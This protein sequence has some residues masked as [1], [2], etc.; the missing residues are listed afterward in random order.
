MSVRLFR[1]HPEIEWALREVAVDYAV[2]TITLDDSDLDP[3]TGNPPIAELDGL[4]LWSHTA[5]LDELGVRYGEPLYPAPDLRPKVRQWLFCWQISHVKAGFDVAFSE[6]RM[7]VLRPAHE[8]DKY[9]RRIAAAHAAGR[10]VVEALN[11]HLH[12]NAFVLG[13]R[14]TVADIA[15]AA[16]ILKAEGGGNDLEGLLSIDGWMDR[17]RDRPAFPERT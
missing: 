7:M 6:T 9:A 3:M 11:A 16:S 8:R 12:R 10:K 13:S 14:F 4:R 17:L 1:N 5:V 15:T 2:E